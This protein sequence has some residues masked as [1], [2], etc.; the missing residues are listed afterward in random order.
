MASTKNIQFPKAKVLQ[1]PELERKNRI[2][3]ERC[4]PYSAPEKT[5]GRLV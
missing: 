2:A 3:A 4:K 5:K 1:G